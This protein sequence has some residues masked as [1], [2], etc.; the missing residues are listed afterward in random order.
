MCIKN[1][2]KFGIPKKQNLNKALYTLHPQNAKEWGNLWDIINQ[3]TSK[4]IE[5][6]MRGKYRVI[7]NKIEN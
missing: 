1:E 6:K 2:I 5:E 4:K 3:N 7:N